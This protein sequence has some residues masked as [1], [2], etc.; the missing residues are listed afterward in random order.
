LTDI[1]ITAFEV[2]QTGSVG[3]GGSTGAVVHR[4][5]LAIRAGLAGRAPV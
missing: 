5:L 3:V 1:A 2:L 4:S